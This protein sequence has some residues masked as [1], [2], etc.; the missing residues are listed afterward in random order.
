MGSLSGGTP[1]VYYNHLLAE[2]MFFGPPYEIDRDFDSKPDDCETT[3]TTLL[4]APGSIWTNTLFPDSDGD[5]LL[6]GEEDPGG[7]TVMTTTLA[8]TNPR[9]YDHDGDGFSDGMEV[10]FM[11][12]DPLDPNDP[13]PGNPDYADSDN[14]GLPYYLDP[15]D[16]DPDFDNDRIRDAYEF[17]HGYDPTDPDDYPPVGDVNGDGIKNNIDAL[18]LF[19]Y[20]LGIVPDLAHK[21]NGDVQIN[22]YIN[23]LDALI[24]F[25]WGLG[26]VSLIPMIP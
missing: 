22:S 7:C 20:S 8:L 11:G 18:L 5:G 3:D 15:D 2:G 25:Y 1:D 14:D 4:S 6:D 21:E 26:N 9:K 12:T 13:D 16:N 23:N 24:L 19:Y 10:L 17:V